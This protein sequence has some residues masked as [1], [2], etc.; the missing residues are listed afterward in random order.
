MA[1]DH[2]GPIGYQGKCP[3]PLPEDIVA[4]KTTSGRAV[5][6]AVLYKYGGT[7]IMSSWSSSSDYPMMLYH[8]VLTRRTDFPGRHADD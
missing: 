3:R 6:Q 4:Q 8:S 2:I 5:H 1:I 7:H